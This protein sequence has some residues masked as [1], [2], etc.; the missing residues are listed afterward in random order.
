MKFR[1]HK[2]LPDGRSVIFDKKEEDERVIDLNV[3]IF[4]DNRKKEK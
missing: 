4:R 3:I 2:I 1:F